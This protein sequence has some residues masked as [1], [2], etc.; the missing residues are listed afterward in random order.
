MIGL[1]LKNRSLL[2][3]LNATK[4]HKEARGEK[5]T[6]SRGLTKENIKPS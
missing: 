5:N 3:E 6:G 1:Y 2:N 4:V